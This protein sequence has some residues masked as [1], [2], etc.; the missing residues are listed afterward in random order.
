M[1]QQ[2]MLG[3]KVNASM[4]RMSVVGSSQDTQGLGILLCSCVQPAG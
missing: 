4:T 1:Q 2:R 3:N